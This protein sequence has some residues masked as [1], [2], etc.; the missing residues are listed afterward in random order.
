MLFLQVA[1]HEYAHAWQGENCPLLNNVL[2]HEGFAE[3]LAY[4]VLEYYHYSQG[5]QRMLQ[6]TDLYGNGL[7]WALDLEAR[8]GSAG[9]VDACRRYL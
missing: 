2:V 1:A 5:Q 7:R 4:R 9:L 8:V 6:R 3:W